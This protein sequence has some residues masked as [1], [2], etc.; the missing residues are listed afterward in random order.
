[1]RSNIKQTHY[2]LDFSDIEDISDNQS[3]S[4]SPQHNQPHDSPP[5]NDIKQ[6]QQGS[7]LQPVKKEAVEIPSLII[8][9]EEDQIQRRKPD[10]L[11]QRW[12]VNF[13]ELSE[14]E[15][16]DDT[17]VSIQIQKEPSPPPQL[18]EP[19]YIEQFFEDQHILEEV[20][21]DQ[22]QLI[23]ERVK[24]VQKPTLVNKQE[25]QLKPQK[26]AFG[27]VNIR[28]ITNSINKQ[29]KEPIN[30][31]ITTPKRDINQLIQQ[32]KPKQNVKQK[33]YNPK[34]SLIYLRL[35]G[36][37]DLYK[38][39]DIVVDEP[40]KPQEV[41]QLLEGLDCINNLLIDLSNLKEK[42]Q[43]IVEKSNKQ[44]T[45][46]IHKR[47]VDENNLNNIEKQINKEDKSKEQKQEKVKQ[48]EKQLEIQSDKQLEIVKQQ[49]QKQRESA[50]KQ[51]LQQEAA[52]ARQIRQEKQQQEKEMKKQQEQKLVY[53]ILTKKLIN[54][55]MPL[56][57]CLL[58]QKQR[59]FIKWLRF[60]EIALINEG[61][62]EIYRFEKR[63]SDQ[64]FLQFHKQNMKSV[65]ITKQC[66]FNPI[67]LHYVQTQE[68][69]Q[70]NKSLEKEKQIKQ[71]FDKGENNNKIN[72]ECKK[73]K[74]KKQPKQKK[75]KKKDSSDCIEIS[76]EDKEKDNEKEKEKDKSQKIQKNRGIQSNSDD[77]DFDLLDADKIQILKVVVDKR[78][79][80]N[81][82]YQQQQTIQH[83]DE[84][85]QHDEGVMIIQGI[86]QQNE[87]KFQQDQMHTQF[88][89]EQQK[90]LN[91]PVNKLGQVIE[92]QNEVKQKKHR[93]YKYRELPLSRLETNDEI[94]KKEKVND[95]R[96]EKKKQDFLQLLNEIEIEQKQKQLKQ[97][98]QKRKYKSIQQNNNK[99]LQKS[100]EKMVGSNNL[101]WFQSV[102]VNSKIEKEQKMKKSK[103]GS[104]I[105]RSEVKQDVYSGNSSVARQSSIEQGVNS[106]NREQVEKKPR[107]LRRNETES[108]D[109]EEIQQLERNRDNH[110]RSK[111]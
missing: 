67:T 84:F 13:D 2:V 25:C 36:R 9:Q 3:E 96:K 64:L 29:Q 75:L 63:M 79:Y 102:D 111:R 48:S 33:F 26:S 49:V 61:E 83:P 103:N 85:K 77:E 51:Q 94:K 100:Y 45:I 38:R 57:R 28:I 101:E 35:K 60:S 58:R 8:Q 6:L 14:Y 53:K 82:Q 62:K 22:E 86:D 59:D 95:K 42:K 46:K 40:P 110:K 39:N 11:I 27:K 5:R 106:P 7:S 19:Q 41:D 32:S 47:R 20:E 97:E 104:R 17:P 80:N 87:Q 23:L 105:T 37:E 66:M 55:G 1:M 81:R 43:N 99:Q 92:N 52:L 69:P 50:Q 54:Q 72:S 109:S 30:D 65:T 44:I 74:E 21:I 71:E 4:S 24:E 90:Y 91:L 15:E 107:R 18:E 68:V 76:K 93:T 10:N 31:I 34:N 56:Y 12:E 78:K 88:Q 16:V 73:Q 89:L 70:E 108:E 98:Q